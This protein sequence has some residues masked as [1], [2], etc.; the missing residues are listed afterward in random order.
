M[1]VA[2]IQPIRKAGLYTQMVMGLLLSLSLGQVHAH[3][4]SER[5]SIVFYYG[6][7]PEE[8][9]LSRFDLAVVE[10]DTGFIPPEA[11]GTQWFAYVSVGEV[12]PSR[13]YYAKIP[14]AWISGYNQEWRSD[15]IDQAADG[16]PAFVVE[17]IITPI[18]E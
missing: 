8:A 6:D 2:A 10:P 3:T 18:R 14:E 1:K 17:H 13:P 9:V 12:S 11:K 5:A 7:Q 16:W 15:I 4:L